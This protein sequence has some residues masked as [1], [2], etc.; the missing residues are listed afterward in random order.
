MAN[1]EFCYR[2]V[3]DR[4]TWLRAKQGI[5]LKVM[6]V[7]GSLVVRNGHR[8]KDSAVVLMAKRPKELAART[9][10]PALFPL[11]R[12]LIVSWGRAVGV[13][14]AVREDE[15]A[16]RECRCLAVEFEQAWATVML[17]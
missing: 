2:D 12:R 9:D 13:V 1:R 4:I 15:R 11:L 5:T 10:V 14:V 16:S 17:Q 7:L 6:T 3:A 8:V